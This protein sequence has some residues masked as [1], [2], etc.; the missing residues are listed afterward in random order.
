MNRSPDLTGERFGRLT[1]IKIARK[2]KNRHILWLCKCDCGNEVTVFASN[3]K[4]GNTISCGCYHKERDSESHI[5]HSQSKTR[6]YSIWIGMKKRCFNRNTKA[7]EYYGGRGIKVCEDWLDF[8][9][10]HDWAKNNGYNDGL[11]LERINVEKDYEPENCKWI[12]FEEQA[13][14][15]RRNVF[16]SFNNKRMT[17]SDWAKE[18]KMSTSILR[19]RLK[20]GWTVEKSLTT[21]VREMKK[22]K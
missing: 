13:K 4:R 9:K 15:T 20:H 8:T 11:S 2:S 18:M 3:L 17:I 22:C 12:P 10:F 21:P 14:N 19:F 5:I 6:L 7:Y 1:C 16:L